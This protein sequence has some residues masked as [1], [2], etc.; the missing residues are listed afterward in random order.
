MATITP[1]DVRFQLKKIINDF[2]ESFF[3]GNNNEYD[4]VFSKSTT[5]IECEFDLSSKEYTG[6]EVLDMPVI[7]TK[8]VKLLNSRN[9]Y[10]SLDSGTGEGLIRRVESYFME[11]HIMDAADNEINTIKVS[12]QIKLLFTEVTQRLFLAT[13]SIKKPRIRIGVGE[14][15]GANIFRVI[16]TLTCEVLVDNT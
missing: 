12:D 3:D 16:C 13:K 5:F 2:F 14:K 15:L 11:F 4:D 9:V 8:N 10:T 6:D 7:Q 1:V